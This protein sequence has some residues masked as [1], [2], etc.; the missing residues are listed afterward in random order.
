MSALTVHV[1]AHH[2]AGIRLS[3]WSGKVETAPFLCASAHLSTAEAE[4]M[5]ADLRKALDSLPRVGTAA[6]LGCEALP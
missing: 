3:I 1:A 4:K 5:I 2:R 6:D